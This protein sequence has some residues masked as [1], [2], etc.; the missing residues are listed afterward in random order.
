[1]AIIIF[2][3]IWLWFYS[4][5]GND[6]DPLV[7]KRGLLETPR[8]K[9]RFLM[10]KSPYTL[11]IYHCHVWWHRRVHTSQFSSQFLSQWYPN[12]IP[13]NLNIQQFQMSLPIPWETRQKLEPTSLEGATSRWEMVHDFCSWGSIIVSPNQNRKCDFKTIPFP[14]KFALEATGCN[15]FRKY[16]WVSSLDLR[17]F[18][19][20]ERFFSSWNLFQYCYARIICFGWL[21]SCVL[22]SFWSKALT[23]LLITFLS[24][25]LRLQGK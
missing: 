20:I 4:Y 1:M 19:W 18:Y 13:I 22:S 24:H 11:G 14:R 12:D 7:I 15:Y 2:G 23:S 10:L 8:T 25:W 6:N 21:K 3:E 9:W 5:N 16:H 17:I